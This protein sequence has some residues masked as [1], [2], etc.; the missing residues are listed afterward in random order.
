MYKFSFKFM[1]EIKTFESDTLDN[2]HYFIGMNVAK[3]LDEK[4]KS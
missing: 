1:D 3:I 4:L 2:I